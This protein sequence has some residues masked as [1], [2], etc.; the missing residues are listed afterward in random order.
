M[1][2]DYR[3]STVFGNKV[4]KKIFWPSMNYSRRNVTTCK[5]PL[6][7]SRKDVLRMVGMTALQ[8][9]N[10]IS[11]VLFPSSSFW[12]KSAS[13]K[14][15]SL[16]TNIPLNRMA[17]RLEANIRQEAREG[18]VTARG[19]RSMG[20]LSPASNDSMAITTEWICSSLEENK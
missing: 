2:S 5:S 7:R 10:F 18:S 9:S 20:I 19:G 8:V 14:H 6:L 12:R 4:S 1:D 11:S 13:P 3:R 16:A 15:V 17:R